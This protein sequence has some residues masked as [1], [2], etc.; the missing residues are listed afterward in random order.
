MFARYARERDAGE[1]FG[2]FVI[3]AG[4]VARVE[5]GRDFSR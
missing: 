2:D 3:R 4:F 1:P 5:A